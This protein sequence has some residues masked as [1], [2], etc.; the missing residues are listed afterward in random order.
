MPYRAA[1]IAK[2]EVDPIANTPGVQDLLDEVVVSHRLCSL[3]SGGKWKRAIWPIS[4][5]RPAR[6]RHS[7][8]LFASL[9]RNDS[10]GAQ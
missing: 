10:Q 9:G 8:G 3:G 2:V 1:R 4:G 7:D 6:L 5:F